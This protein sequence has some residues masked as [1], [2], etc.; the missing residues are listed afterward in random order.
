MS[1]LRIDDLIRISDEMTN[2]ATVV[3]YDMGRTLAV[4]VLRVHRLLYDVSNLLTKIIEPFRQKSECLP[5][6]LPG[7]EITRYSVLIIR[8]LILI[9][10]HTL[11]LVVQ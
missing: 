8:L 1:I 6:V 10:Y 4:L 11:I 2:Q 5:V 7:N 3:D 9:L